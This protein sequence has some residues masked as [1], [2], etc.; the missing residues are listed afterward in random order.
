MKQIKLDSMMNFR[1]RL[2]ISIF[3]Q[4][5]FSI[6]SFKKNLRIPG[7]KK[8]EID[9][10]S[11]IDK[12]FS[13]TTIE[14]NEAGTILNFKPG[15][16]RERKI[17][18]QINSL[19]GISYYIEFLLYLVSLNSFKTEIKLNGLRALNLDVSL[20]NIIYV[21][22]PLMRKIGIRDVRIKVFTNYFSLINNV[23]ILMFSP[24]FLPHKGFSL[25]DSGI[26]KKIRVIFSYSSK[27][28]FSSIY[29]E[30]FRELFFNFSG[31]NSKVYW[32]KIKNSN[33]FFQNISIIGE[34]STGCV[35]GGD[36]CSTN[37]KNSFYWKK[38]ASN[39]FKSLVYL[40]KNGSCLDGSSQ[41][42]IFLR[43][44]LINDKKKV[45]LNILKL[46]LNSINFFR[47]TKKMIGLIF[48]I[49]TKDENNSLL[50]TLT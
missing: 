48:S 35:L 5:N 22:I 50:I 45:K 30:D 1:E 28:P 27:N 18:H 6:I 7:L 9:L 31:L 41:G 32:I 33:I 36:F 34:T 40:C 25:A 47:D 21:T 26:L 49:R 15:F 4:K 29:L 16:Y 14:I 10:L 44:L 24:N 17:F 43:M 46:T 20:E 12:M 3:S 42:I 13:Y 8:Y 2:A 37:I 23:E 19:R 39:I 38:K 11:L